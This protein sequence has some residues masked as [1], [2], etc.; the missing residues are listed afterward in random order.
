M[1]INHV[2][3]KTNGLSFFYF[4]LILCPYE[5]LFAHAIYSCGK[6]RNTKQKAESIESNENC[7]KQF[8]VLEITI[9]KVYS[10]ESYKHVLI[11]INFPHKRGLSYKTSPVELH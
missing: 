3:L 10:Y 5:A 11:A 8:I 2:Q 1:R 6:N 7:F 9:N 4:K